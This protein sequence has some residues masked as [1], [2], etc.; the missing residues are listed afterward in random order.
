MTLIEFLKTDFNR[1]LFPLA[2]PIVFVANGEAQLRSFVY[3]AIFV[4][5]GSPSASFFPTPVAFALKDKLHLRKLLVLDP[6][7]TFYLYDFILRNSSTFQKCRV[8][9]RSRYGYAFQGTDAL[10]PA[11]QYHDFRR[12][13]YQLKE[14]Y[15]YFAKTDIANCFN[16]LYHHRV[17][18]WVETNISVQESV[19]FG[20]FLREINVGESVNCFP[21]GIHPAKTLGNFY[22]SFIESSSEL[23]SPA[24]ARFLDDTYFFSNSQSQLE[25]DVIVLQQML[26]AHSLC[27]NSSKTAFGSKQSDFEEHQL[28]G[29]K[30][31][32]LEKRERTVSGDDDYPDEEV[33][34]DASEVDYLKN[35]IQDPAVAEEDVELGLSLLREEETSFLELAKLVFGSY[36][37]LVKS[38]YRYLRSVG[39]D[40]DLRTILSTR[41][42]EQFLTEFELFWIA[43]MVIDKLEMSKEAATLLTVIL[44]HPCATSLVKAAVVEVEENSFGLE[45][46]KTKLLRDSPGNIIGMSALAGIRRLPRSKRNYLCGY[47]AKTSP[48][49]GVLSEIIRSMP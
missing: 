29:I 8:S 2:S 13:K 38:L 4:T 25:R 14:H 42:Q 31:R 26:G 47:V 44:G 12:R 28:D 36:P 21:Q 18:Q 46:I 33:E 19:Q 37:H 7:A 11:P 20:R 17:N 23:T 15:S 45:D 41:L 32:L 9:S 27:L 30:K 22:L 1:S 3:D 48:Y 49:L 34:L 10:P 6:I 5:S 24:L 43:R 39:S 35:L 16:S 40:A